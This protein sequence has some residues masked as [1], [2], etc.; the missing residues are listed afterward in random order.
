MVGA[1]AGV[2]HNLASPRRSRSSPPPPRAP[3]EYYISPLPGKGVSSARVR[4]HEMQQ[5]FIRVHLEVKS[6]FKI[7]T[8]AAADTE[9]TAT[10]STGIFLSVL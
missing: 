10:I 5:V 7:D 9:I 4:S 1:V 3:V 2:K 6:V 8:S